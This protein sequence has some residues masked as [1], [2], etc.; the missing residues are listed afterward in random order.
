VEEGI[1]PAEVENVPAGY[2]TTLQGLPE[3]MRS[4]LLYGDFS[5]GREDDAWQVIPTAWIKAAM[6]RRKPEGARRSRCRKSARILPMPDP[7]PDRSLKRK[8]RRG[9]IP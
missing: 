3:P 7:H 8:N 5:V 1:D 2:V 9:G 6:D 4:Q